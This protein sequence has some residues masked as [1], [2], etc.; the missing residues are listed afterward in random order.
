VWAASARR[1]RFRGLSTTHI[2]S[3]DL[4]SRVSEL[5]S[6]RAKITFVS[7][8]RSVYARFKNDFRKDTFLI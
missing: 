8:S 3:I 7:N 6:L 5:F 4:F 1:R 2:N